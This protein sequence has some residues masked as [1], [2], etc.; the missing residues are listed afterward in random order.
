MP[1][2][3]KEHRVSLIEDYMKRRLEYLLSAS[4]LSPHEANEFALLR[5]WE[6]AKK[7]DE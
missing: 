7:L 5:E 6:T 3:T 2:E 4:G 1:D